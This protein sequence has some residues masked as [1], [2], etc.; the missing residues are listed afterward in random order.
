MEGHSFCL[1]VVCG[2]LFL[3]YSSYLVSATQFDLYKCMLNQKRIGQDLHQIDKKY[4]CIFSEHYQNNR[5]SQKLWEK[6]LFSS[7]ESL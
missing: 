1:S 7:F 2:S 3:I 4:M 5:I 6:F